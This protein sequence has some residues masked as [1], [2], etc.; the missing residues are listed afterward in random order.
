MQKMTPEQ[1]AAIKTNRLDKTVTLTDAQKQQVNS[2][3][4]EEAKASKER[5]AQR[6]ETQKKVEA[7]LTKEQAQ[8][9]EAAQQKR[10]EQMRAMH[11][12]R[13]AKAKE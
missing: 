6:K 4:L 7:V 13:K 10:M 3:Y 1:I 5:M 2:I 9:F 12:E 8:K 11:A